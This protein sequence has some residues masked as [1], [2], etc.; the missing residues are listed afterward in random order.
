MK[1]DGAR[2]LVFRVF[3]SAHHPPP[4][5]AMFQQSRLLAFSCLAV[6]ACETASLPTIDRGAPRT[7][8]TLEIVG[9]YGD[10]IPAP[11]ESGLP[12]GGGALARIAAIR[13]ATDGSIFVLDS[14]YKKLVQ[15]ARD[16]SVV[17]VWGEGFGEGPGE[18]RLPTALDVLNEGS[19]VVYDFSLT[20]LTF[21]SPSG[22]VDRILSI[23][24]QWKDFLVEDTVVVASRFSTRF[25]LVEVA[26]A[27]TG[28]R[29][30]LEVPPPEGELEFSPQGL[31]GRLARTADGSIIMA[32]FRPS[33]W[34]RRST[35][36]WLRVGGH[37]VPGIPAVQ[38]DDGIIQ[39]AGGIQGITELPDGRVAIL[40]QRRDDADGYGA[41]GFHVDVYTPA[42]S[43]LGSVQVDASFVISLSSTAD[44]YLLL[45]VLEPFPQ[46]LRA[47]LVDAPRAP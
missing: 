16:G 24:R 30:R 9:S 12:H 47:R 23:G 44:G 4:P 39:T 28:E 37:A 19:V 25:E 33:T 35:S 18:F 27:L 5:S 8:F 7:S 26:S 13:G 36:G 3:S 22:E 1:S 34:Y 10:S 17:K 29:L 21:F 45:S 6:A 41:A 20:R 2:G 14:E 32:D 11:P 42:G 46:V 43:F 40:Y 31:L 15:F 38:R